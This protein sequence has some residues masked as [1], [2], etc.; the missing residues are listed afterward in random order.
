[1]QIQVKLQTMQGR[2]HTS[3]CENNDKQA[4]VP[5]PPITS[6]FQP[7]PSNTS[8]QSTTGLPAIPPL[9]NAAP[10]N[11]GC[12]LKTA[13]AIVQSGDYQCRAHILFDE[14]AQKSFITE[15]LAKSLHIVPSRSQ[16][17]HVSAFGGGTT[18]KSHLASVSVR[19]NDGEVPM[20]VLV[21]PKIAAPLQNL[22]PSPGDCYPYL[23]GLPL[24][25]PVQAIDKFDISLLV[26]ADFYWQIVQDRV[27]RGNGP[28]GEVTDTNR[29]WNV[30]FTGTIAKSSASL[31]NDQRIADYINSSV[32]HQTDG[33]YIVRFPWKHNHPYLPSN[34]GIC[35]KQTRSLAR[36]LARTPE[37]LQIYGNIIA[38][39]LTR[40]FIEKVTESD[41]PQHCHFIPHHAVKKES[42]TTPIRIVYDCSCRQSPHHPCLNDCLEVGPPFLIDLCTLLLRFRTHNICNRHRE[43]F[44]HVQLEEADR[45]FTHLVWLSEV[46]N[47]E[48][49]FEIYRFHVVLFDCVSSPF[50]LH[51]ALRCHLNH[52]HSI[53]SRDI[54]AN[55]YVDNVVSGCSNV[56]DALE[57]YHNARQLISNAHFNL[58]SWASN[59]P[60]VR[61]RAQQDGVA[62]TAVTV[63]VLG[64]MW[65]TSQDTLRLAD[66]AFLSLDVAQPTKKGV[67]QDLSRVFDPLGML[68]PSYHIGKIVYATAVAK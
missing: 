29:F 53:T 27:V 44:P 8:E 34:R 33:S 26:G 9:T 16:I 5:I 55:L 59:S 48:S 60:E 32:C 57:Y 36:K 25:H 14:G 49:S 12:L 4:K 39:Q 68:T 63:N 47:P 11:T 52:E 64:L 41:V 65:D 22:I 42:A 10:S 50:M 13:I 23:R 43:G 28:T 54:L 6:E 58:R 2:H 15:Q 67:L 66:R 45:K 30:E 37:L 46:D 35:E 38:E 61:T 40:G 24:A 20:S 18:P 56:P 7:L 1:M 17:I 62:D 19:T 3:I 21:I 31:A 51:A